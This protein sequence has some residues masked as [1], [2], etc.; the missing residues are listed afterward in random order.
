MRPVLGAALIFITSCT[1][2]LPA[3]A[4]VPVSAP[5]PQTVVEPPPTHPEL[6]AE[7]KAMVDA[8]QEARRRLLKDQK[9]AQIQ[10]EVTARAETART[11]LSACESRASIVT[12]RRVRWIT[13]AF[14]AVRTTEARTRISEGEGTTAPANRACGT[15]SHP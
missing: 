5:A 13:L 8:D 10:A 3:P 4:P 6:G 9:N 14:Q 15:A 11:R 2:V 7:L 12:G 1:T